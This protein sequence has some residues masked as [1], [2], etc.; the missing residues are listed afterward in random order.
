MRRDKGLGSIY[1]R[2]DGLWVAQYKGQYLYSKDKATA[3]HK[4]TQ[5]LQQ[6]DQA[7]PTNVTVG[8]AL[9]QYLES[10]KPNLKPRTVY[11]YSEACRVHL[12][13]ALGRTKLHKLT[14]LE[15]EGLYAR[16]LGSGSSPATVRLVHA[17]LSS[18]IKKAVRLELVQG[19][20]CRDVQLPKLDTP[21]VQVFSPD[22]VA[23]ILAAAR[24]DR[25]NALWVL[26]L[27]T[28]AREGELLGLQI[29]DYDSSTSKLRIC[30]TIYNGEVSTPKSKHGNRNIKLPP[31]ASTALEEHVEKNESHRWIFTNTQGGPIHSSTFSRTY[32]KPLLVKAGVPYRNF[33]TCRHT[34]A[35]NLLS[36][37]LPIPAV[38]AYLGHTPQ[39][40]LKT[41]AHVMNNDFDLI[42]VALDE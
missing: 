28:G 33:H 4:L 1:K 10:S 16:M 9:D 22:K 37:Q 14:A 12:K 26:A 15:I 17:V 42:A 5:M 32:W 2:K 29:Q 13:P 34:T 24:E 38:A 31:K 19:D 27:T 21:E 23:I 7:R 36:K 41:Y 39:T 35:S 18:A 25:L 3:K 11:R 20:V 40:L 8:S 6:P 30:R